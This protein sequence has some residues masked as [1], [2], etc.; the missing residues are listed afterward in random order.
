MPD[1]SVVRCA[2]L[3]PAQRGAATPAQLVQ[4]LQAA[5]Q[6][7]ESVAGDAALVAAADR[8]I[9]TQLLLRN[10]QQQALVLR[11]LADDLR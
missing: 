4:L 1:A 9:L 3:A 6:V 7:A 5:Q 8:A 11:A 2:A 10:V